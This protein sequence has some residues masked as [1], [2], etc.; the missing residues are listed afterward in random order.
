MD[1]V[2]TPLIPRIQAIFNHYASTVDG[3]HGPVILVRDVMTIFFELGVQMSEREAE[4]LIL[5]LSEVSS[6]AVRVHVAP[7]P[8][9]D[10]VDPSNVEPIVPP[11]SESASDNDGEDP[12]LDHA[13]IQEGEIADF[14]GSSDVASSIPS[15]FS[16]TDA[17]RPPAGLD[18]ESFVKLLLTTLPGDSRQVDM[19]S[20]FVSL[21][22]DEDGVIGQADLTAAF[23][24]YDMPAL[25]RRDI[26]AI[27]DEADVDGDG[28]VTVVDMARAVDTV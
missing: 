25:P 7:E 8:V 28:R 17:T 11:A 4:S 10:I 22:A 26:E 12:E 23:S 1:W 15:D 27:L 19:A 5:S 16:A 9:A 3:N 20:A 21:D 24:R 18:F 6:S 13:D 2:E 14:D